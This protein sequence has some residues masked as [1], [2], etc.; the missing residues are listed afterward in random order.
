MEGRAQADSWRRRALILCVVVGVFWTGLLAF[1]YFT[2][3]YYDWDLAFNVQALWHLVRGGQ[4]VP[5]FGINFFGDH[6]AFLSFLLVPLFALFPSALLLLVLKAVAFSVA[7][8]LLYRFSEDLLG[9]W[10][11]FWILCLFV[12]FPPNIFGLL[13]EF[14]YEVF[15]PP[16]IM[17][18][19]FSLRRRHVRGLILSGIFLLMVKENMPL[20]VLFFSILACLQANKRDRRILVLFS[21]F[22]L[23]YFLFCVL[24]FVPCQ[25]GS[26]VH[27][28]L[29]RYAFLVENMGGGKAS[30][31][32]TFWGRGGEY[33]FNLF[34]PLFL[35]ILSP[36]ALVPMLPLF[37]QHLLSSNFLEQTAFYYY[38]QTMAPFVFVAFVNLLNRVL[39][40]P[41]FRQYAGVFRMFLSCV[42]AA[43]VILYAGEIRLFSVGTIS[44]VPAIWRIVHQIPRDEGVVA[45]FRFLPVLAA[46]EE[47]YAFHKIYSQDFQD[48]EKMREGAFFDGRGPFRLPRHIRY[49]LIDL[50][51]PWISVA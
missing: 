47:L 39:G 26:A 45:T 51:D 42:L 37:L 8:W 23:S 34:G 33:V 38:G 4:F 16:L 5:L 9:G 14:N 17:A 1:K 15:A 10:W 31:L 11:G 29:S 24:L 43:W 48:S 41:F 25:R 32:A 50:D 12:F 21:L 19:F 44:D 3:H 13:Y 28:F 20:V 46:R 27:P 30:F 18:M 7:A 49:A 2:F 22:C 36:G 6:A 35:A 40:R